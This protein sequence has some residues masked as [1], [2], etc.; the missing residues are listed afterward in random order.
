MMRLK[1]RN[2]EKSRSNGFTLMEVMIAIAII[3]LLAAVAMPL[4]LKSLG[5]GQKAAVKMQIQAFESGVTN[6]QIDTGKLPK[7]L[8]NLMCDDG[9]KNWDG[10]YLGK[11]EIPKDPW[12]NDYVYELDS[13]S[14]V[15][16]KITSYG[17]DGVPG[18]EGQA[19]DITNE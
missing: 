14:P 2:S 17:S 9:Y 6:F 10:P 12:G 5:K 19:A 3:M 4:V 16:Y 7:S 13:D 11:K 15:G 1:K 8:D 18:G